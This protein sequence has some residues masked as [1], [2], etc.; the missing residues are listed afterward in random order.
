V[1]P[2]ELGS[3]LELDVVAGLFANGV[4]C[5]IGAAL[6]TVLTGRGLLDEPCEGVAVPLTTAAQ[7]RAGVLFEVDILISVFVVLLNTTPEGFCLE[8]EYSVCFWIL[9]V[10]DVVMV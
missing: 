8:V 7:E 6:L 10:Q 9:L 3:V 4:S 5:W 2:G 1:E